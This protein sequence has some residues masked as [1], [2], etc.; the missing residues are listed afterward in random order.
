MGS[1][2][3]FHTSFIGLTRPTTP[4]E[5]AIFPHYV[6]VTNGQ[7]DGQIVRTTTELDLYQQADED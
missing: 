2:P 5:L 3:L 1:G 4:N 6:F 7:T